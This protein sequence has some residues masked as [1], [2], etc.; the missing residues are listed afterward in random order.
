MFHV[1]AQDFI[2]SCRV[3]PDA[4]LQMA[5]QLTV[6]RLTGRLVATY[7]SA[8]TRRFRLG[9]VDSIRWEILS[10]VLQSCCHH[11]LTERHVVVVQ[12]LSHN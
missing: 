12:A 4:W 6:Y 10:N 2:K 8:S 3:S 1:G 11:C 5:L 7:E 9:R